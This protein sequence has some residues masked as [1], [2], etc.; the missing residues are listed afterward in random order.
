MRSKFAHVIYVPGNHELWLENGDGF[1][2]SPQK[3]FRILE[4]CDALDVITYPVLLGDACLVVPLFGW[5]SPDFAGRDAE[6]ALDAFDCQ[7]KWPAW[8]SAGGP[9]IA[10]SR[11]TRI[12]QF[13][14]SLN[15]THVAAARAA[16]RSRGDGAPE[17]YVVA[18]SH[19]LPR[20]DLFRGPAFLRGVMGTPRL[21]DALDA[22]DA[23]ACVYGHSHLDGDSVLDDVR[24]VQ[25]SLGHGPKDGKPETARALKK[26]TLLFSTTP[27][28]TPSSSP[29]SP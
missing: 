18:V 6:T 12:A 5:H 11:D 27:L 7:C 1:A 21:L 13:F 17:R 28:M 19:F 15:A 25:N 23:A 14:L 9:P 2:D 4:L 8:L 22:I 3:F 10:N 24:Y 26:P 16:A 29:R 20:P